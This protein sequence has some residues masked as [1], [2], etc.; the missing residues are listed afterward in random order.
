MYISD[1]SLKGK[2]SVG[3]HDFMRRCYA[4]NLNTTLFSGS[5]RNA[6]LPLDFVI[7]FLGFSVWDVLIIAP[8]MYRA[9]RS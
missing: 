2:L 3:K 9:S 7:T 8:S 1:F 6:R 5:A 4:Y